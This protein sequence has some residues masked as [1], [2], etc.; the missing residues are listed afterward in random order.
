VAA[1]LAKLGVHRRS[2]AIAAARSGTTP[3]AAPEDG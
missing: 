2:E 3:A 1:V